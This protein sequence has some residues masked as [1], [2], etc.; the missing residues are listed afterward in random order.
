MTAI[1]RVAATL[2]FAAIL[3][4]CGADPSGVTL[5]LKPMI[6]D[7]V[8]VPDDAIA[9]VDG[10]PATGDVELSFDSMH[11]AYETEVVVELTRGGRATEVA[12]I[13]PFET[14]GTAVDKLRVE[15]G[16]AGLV[17][18]F[19]EVFLFTASMRRALDDGTVA[20]FDGPC[21]M[22]TFDDGRQAGMCG[23]GITAGPVVAE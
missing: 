14:C 15:P 12:A 10:Q 22:C 18:E 21:L 17:Q 6:L 1:L 13:R 5:I 3:A 11:A 23:L 19:T 4:S 7:P 16:P 9:L 2:L 8:A 20:L